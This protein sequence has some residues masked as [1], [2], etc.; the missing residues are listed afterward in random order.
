MAQAPRSKAEDEEEGIVQYPSAAGPR[1]KAKEEEE[2]EEEGI[3]KYPSAGPRATAAEEEDEEEGVVDYPAVGAGS[4][5]GAGSAEQKDLTGPDGLGDPSDWD[6]PP[7]EIP[8]AGPR[9]GGGAAASSVRI[10]SSKHNGSCGVAVTPAVIVCTTSVRVSHHWQLLAPALHVIVLLQQI[11]SPDERNIQALIVVEG[12]RL[13]LCKPQAKPYTKTQPAGERP[14]PRVSVP[15][16]VS[17][18]AQQPGGS[19]AGGLSVSPNSRWAPPPGTS[20]VRV[21][22]RNPCVF[23]LRSCAIPALPRH[24]QRRQALTPTPQ[25]ASSI[26]HR[27]HS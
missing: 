9:R 26:T 16:P 25:A 19:P 27:N 4:R 23:Q 13:G 20:P 8:H 6:P 18:A 21:R 12:T 7:R 24:V 11:C 3:V 17:S 22:C 5:R 14:A 1:S 10:Q 2:D 15:P